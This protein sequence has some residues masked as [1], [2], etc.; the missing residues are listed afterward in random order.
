MAVSQLSYIGV[1]V[2]DTAAW[3]QFATEVL[4]MQVGDETESGVVY[5]RM[6]EY[7]HRVVLHPTGEDDILYTGFQAPTRAEYDE[8]RASLETLGVRLTQGTPEELEIRKVVDLVKFESGGLSFEL[9]YGPAVTYAKPFTPGRAI[10]GFK[11]GDLGMGHIVLRSKDQT[12]TVRVLTEGLGFRLSDY[13][14]TMVF[15]HCNPRHHTIA[16]QPAPV[17]PEGVTIKKMWHFMLE[18]NS[19][20]D[21]GLGFDAAAKTKTE[22]VTTIGKH[23]NDHMV[24][25]Y[26]LTPSGFEIEYGWGGRM[27]DDSTWQVVRHFNGDIWGHKSMRQQP[28][29]MPQPVAA[30]VA[31]R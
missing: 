8:A 16:I 24:S 30:A 9:S 20:D 29:A 31:G 15:M 26:V 28:L 7:H 25:F 21:V 13:V 10:S 5:L 14:N 17:A 18:L 6:D 2:S 3:K 12:E 23:M 19:L 1:G 11:T 27:I 4:G 22:P